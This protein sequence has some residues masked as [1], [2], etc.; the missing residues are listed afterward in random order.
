MAQ[1]A[2]RP[3]RRPE[4]MAI[5]RAI[6]GRA[7]TS[8]QLLTHILWQHREC[9]RRI[10]AWV[11]RARQLCLESGHFVGLAQMELPREPVWRRGS[12]AFI[13]HQP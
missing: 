6:H 9:P 10:T 3:E 2:I 11:R 4:S 1:L 13:L 12:A 8:R 5:D 7:A